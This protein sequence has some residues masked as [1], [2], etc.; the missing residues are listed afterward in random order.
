MKYYLSF[1]CRSDFFQFIQLVFDR[2]DI[3][4]LS[5]CHGDYVEVFDLGKEPES[6]NLGQLCGQ[7]QN[8]VIISSANSLRIDFHTDNR[9]TM[10]QSSGFHAHFQQIS[11][12]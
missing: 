1:K 5:R 12:G 2:I 11:A 7:I 8:H 6:Q 9:T 4:E 3:C 10:Q